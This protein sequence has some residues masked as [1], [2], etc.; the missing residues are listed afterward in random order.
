MGARDCRDGNLAL[1][2]IRMEIALLSLSR[3]SKGRNEVEILFLESR[4]AN[5][6]TKTYRI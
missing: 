1:L 6:G 2:E 4:T 3:D 5:D